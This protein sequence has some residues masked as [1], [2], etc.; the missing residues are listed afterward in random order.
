MAGFAL[1]TVQLGLP[2]GAANLT[3]MPTEEQATELVG[4]AVKSGVASFDTADAYV[5]NHRLF[6]LA[7]SFL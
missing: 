7:P 4:F 2:Y 1:G 6:F 5:P 3:G